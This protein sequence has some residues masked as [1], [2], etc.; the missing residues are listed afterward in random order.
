MSMSASRQTTNAILMANAVTRKDP[1]LAHVVRDILGM[2]LDAQVNCGRDH[3]T[4]MLLSDPACASFV[5]AMVPEYLHC[6][7][8][9]S[10]QV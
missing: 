9:R 10:S 5:G 6:L 8:S 7:D 1:I 2:D 3:G 4:K